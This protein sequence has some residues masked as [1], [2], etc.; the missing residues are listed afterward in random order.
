MN[1]LVLDTETFDFDKIA[2]DIAWNVTDEFGHI[3]AHKSYLV[4]EIFEF[5]NRVAGFIKHSIF[6]K[7]KTET[8]EQA[9]KDEKIFVRPLT[10]I[11]ED[12]LLDC[13]KFNVKII[14]AYNSPFDSESL[15]NTMLFCGYDYPF[16]YKE[17]SDLAVFACKALMNSKN[18]FKFAIMN[19]L[20][21][22]KG[23]VRTTAESC[24]KYI[25]GNVNFT[26]DHIAYSDVQ[27]ETAILIKCLQTKKK[28]E[29]KTS[30][31]TW[32]IPQEKF[33]KFVEKACK[34]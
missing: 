26:E 33:H 34:E 27:I 12:F 13:E 18:Y 5:K 8:Y 4:K 32:R 29:W 20:V 16:T 1:Y 2:F 6:S 14:C 9:I 17:W 25:T 30:G 22:E 10:E 24:Y 23:N 31:L 19:G 28:Q 11:R 7:E 21:S 15:N 3:L